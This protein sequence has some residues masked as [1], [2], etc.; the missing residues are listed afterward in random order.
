MA[1]L[2]YFSVSEL[3]NYTFTNDPP[4]DIL[5]IPECSYQVQPQMMLY[6]PP[7]NKTQ[8]TSFIKRFTICQSSAVPETDLY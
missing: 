6:L 7:L 3:Q 4:F 2:V 5:G 1:K 8:M